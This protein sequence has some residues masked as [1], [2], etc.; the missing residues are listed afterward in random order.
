[1][2]QE[3]KKNSTAD[4]TPMRRE[5]DFTRSCFFDDK[6]AN[7]KI[8]F[9]RESLFKKTESVSKATVTVKNGTNRVNFQ[10][11]FPCSE[12]YLREVPINFTS[13]IADE[14]RKREKKNELPLG[15]FAIK[16]AGNRKLPALPFF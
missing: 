11:K 7:Y 16:C 5:K 10:N 9:R 2:K 3:K 13:F 1:M 8:K 15:M 6:N 4:S 14:F 12:Y